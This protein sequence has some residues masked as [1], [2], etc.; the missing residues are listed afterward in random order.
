M[1]AVARG[2][3]TSGHG[4]FPLLPQASASTTAADFVLA[5]DL[6]GT[7]AF[8]V[9]GAFTATRT[10]RLDLVGVLVLGVITAI[11]GGI[12]R[13]VRIG[14][15]PPSA[16]VQWYYLAV[17]GLGAMIASS[18]SFHPVCSRVP[19]SSLTPSV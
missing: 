13:D 12:M 2:A 18:S 1:T 6:L 8:A 15:V 5:I 11:G 19:W 9:N 16:L 14:A 17:A 7:L 3:A 4:P 10:V